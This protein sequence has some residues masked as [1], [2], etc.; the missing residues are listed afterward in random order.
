[1]ERRASAM[2]WLVYALIFVVNA[3]A[4]A[5]FGGPRVLVVLSAFTGVAAVATALAAM[6]G[7]AGRHPRTA[8]ASRR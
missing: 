8:T 4:F 5:Y 2:P 7:R 6:A 1:M 3:L